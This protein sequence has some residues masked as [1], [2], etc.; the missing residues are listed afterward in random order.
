MSFL[1]GLMKVDPIGAMAPGPMKTLLDP[2]RWALDK[3]IGP[4]AESFVTGRFFQDKLQSAISTDDTGNNA[5]SS[6]GKGLLG[7]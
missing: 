2:S 4:K 3:T 6:T 1:G 7:Q 5:T